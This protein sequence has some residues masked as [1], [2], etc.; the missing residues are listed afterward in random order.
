MTTKTLACLRFVALFAALAIMAV[1][2]LIAQT[3][4]TSALTGAVTDPSGAAVPNVTVTLTSTDTNQVRTATTGADGVY[5]FTLLPPG[6][7]R[8]RF[9][10]NGFKTSEV[11]AVNLNVTETPV[12]DRRLEVGAQNEQVTVVASAET[13][14][15]ATS[16]LG[17]TVGATQVTAIPLANR[18]YTQILGLAAGASAPPNNATAFGKATQ[19]ISTNGADPAQNNFQMDGVAINNIA[20]AGSSN[21]G[22]GGIYTG[23]GIPSPDAIQEFKIQTSTFDASYGRNPGANVNVVTK[24]GTN[25]FH[26]TAFEFFRNSELN[27]ND[28]FYNRDVC[29]NY[30]AGSCPKQVFNQN[31]FGGVVGGPIK[32]DKIFFF[33]SYQGTRQKNGVSAAGQLTGVTLPPMPAGD[34]SAPGW[35]AQLAAMNC[36]FPTLSNLVTGGAA[37]ALACDGSNI[38][39]VALKILNLKVPDGSY[40]IPSS[41]TS[42]YLATTISDP[43][44]YNA[45]QMV[46]NGDY[47]VNSKNTLAMRYFYTRDPQLLQL[48]GGFPGT[49]STFFYS[50]TDAVLKLTTILTNSLVNEARGSFQ[51]NA[52]QT[53]AVLPTGFSNENLGITGLVSDA[54][55]GGINISNG[56]QIP[57]SIIMATDGFTIFSDGGPAFSPTTQMQVADQIS[58]T[59][60]KHTTR[61]G[62]E[63][64][65]TQWNIVFAAL[66]KGLPLFLDFNSLLVG[67][68]SSIDTCIFCTKNGNDGIIHGYR[69]PNMNTFVQDDWKV[70]SKLTLNMGVRWEYDGMLSDKYGNLSTTWIQNL[71]P[72]SQVPTTPNGSV[73]AYSGW[74]VPNNFVAHYGQP[75]A[76]VAISPLS[77][78]LAE[79][80][81]LS[82]FAPRLG[83]AYQVNSKLVLRGGAGLFYDRVAANQ[84]VHSVEQ[85]NPYA[86]TVDYTGVNPNTLA[87][88]FPALPALGSFAQRYANPVPACMV[89]AADV[90]AACDAEL[91]LPFIQP[92]QHT[93]LARQYNFQLQYNFASSWVLE[94]GYVGESAINLVDAYHNYNQAQLASPSNPINGV[95]TNTLENLQFRVPYL[96]Y[97]PVGLSGTGYD[98]ISN[99]NSLQVTARKSF[100][101]GFLVQAAYTWSKAMTDENGQVANGNDAENLAQQYG[102]AYFNRPQRFVM[103]YSWDLP[104]GKH[105]GALDKVVG[106]WNLSGVTTIQSGNLFTIIDSAGGTIYG[107][108]TTSLTQGYSRAQLCPGVTYG[109]MYSPG[110]IEARLGGNSGGPGWFNSNAFCAPPKIGDGYDYGDMGPGAAK[111]PAEFN[112]DVTLMKNTRIGER[113]N[114][115]FR[116]EFFNLFNHSQFNAPGTVLGVGNPTLPLPDVNSAVFGR[117]TS[118]AVNPRVIQL[119]LKYIF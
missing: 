2:S 25:S 108:S 12:L 110:G 3:A 47:L 30:A 113:Q 39:P 65:E 54:V 16:S 32:K 74:V 1:P 21:D 44:I 88:P 20:N 64:E 66:S 8:V 15:T 115:Q 49:P 55:K 82:N 48:N 76:G 57:P 80:P 56:V 68:P 99:Y 116:A 33:A 11:S 31:Q 97:Q 81:P 22:G 103:N 86:V 109:S 101:H 24:S 93:P 10:A 107:T 58:W 42:K 28:F 119:G 17:T 89:G 79:H 34:R 27:A 104:F 92:H 53:S 4:G 7:Y 100:T 63:Y 117:I 18:N 94:V 96:G 98:L 36:G 70:S 106:G 62:Y 6:T 14:Q 84:F 60:G 75:P 35:A 26:G 38:S 43:A 90:S 71:V 77:V 51:R 112:F 41:G 67:G 40:Y 91:S 114:I 23:I 87:H 9:V 102:P 105:T 29:Q 83:F 111:G 95:T 5:R 118:M 61:A 69:L 46:L 78:P 85:G 72:N 37:A 59:H 13:L 19:D 45:N 52:S 50:N 73:A